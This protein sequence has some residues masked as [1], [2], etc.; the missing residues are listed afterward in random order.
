MDIYMILKDGAD[1]ESQ[2]YNYLYYKYSINIVVWKPD[3]DINELVEALFEKVRKQRAWKLFVVDKSNLY[4]NENLYWGN[5][6]EELLTLLSNVYFVNGKGGRRPPEKIYVIRRRTQSILSGKSGDFF[7]VINAAVPSCRF[8]IMDYSEKEYLKELEKLKLVSV[9]VLLGINEIPPEILEAYMVYKVEVT[10]DENKLKE[11]LLYNENNLMKR[12]S[13]LKRNYQ[14]LAAYS[15]QEIYSYRDYVPKLSINTFHPL[16]MSYL[17]GGISKPDEA[18][19]WIEKKNEIASR[20]DL[21]KKEQIRHQE[22]LRREMKNR[23]SLLPTENM[24]LDEEEEKEIYEKI[25][26]NQKDLNECYVDFWKL[27]DELVEDEL[28]KEKELEKILNDR[29]SIKEVLAVLGGITLGL[30]V[31]F[32]LL[33]TVEIKIKTG[34]GIIADDEGCEML[35]TGLKYVGKYI[36]L[37]EALFCL[38]WQALSFVDIYK[39]IHAFN[40]VLNKIN[41]SI[42]VNLA[43]YKKLFS[44]VY[45]LRLCQSFLNRNE[46]FKKWKKECLGNLKKEENDFYSEKEKF[47][48]FQEV[49]NY[50]L[51]E[52]KNFNKKTTDDL[53]V[54]KRNQG[55]KINGNKEIFNPLFYISKISI[56]KEVNDGDRIG[57]D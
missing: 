16:R 24:S 18:H 43:K 51:S 53:N 52:E 9:I 39:A 48:G 44:L 42:R 41:Q 21:I 14:Q 32:I 34:L 20:I 54:D 2:I 38:Y 37:F 4:S 7:Y 50:L 46:N 33:F 36:I 12:E 13:D 11:F 10:I 40:E 22:E 15:K 49:F 17:F 23:I 45:G 27:N 5:E 3:K 26:K 31:P 6:S 30:I 35:I 56:T 1:Q 28:N 8:L 25:K 19:K 55:L 57:M 47:Y 29:Y